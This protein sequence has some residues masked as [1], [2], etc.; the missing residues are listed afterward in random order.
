MKTLRDKIVILDFETATVY[1]RTIPKELEGQDEDIVIQG[2][3]E[4]LGL[5]ESDTHYML[6]ELTI[7]EE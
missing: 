3:C 5:R 6:G 4:E 1:I 2:M 7:N